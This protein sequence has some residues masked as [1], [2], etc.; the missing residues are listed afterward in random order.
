VKKKAKAAALDATA[1]KGNQ[2]GK[3]QRAARRRSYY[4][5]QFMR[6]S[7]NKRRRLR[8]HLRAHPKDQRAIK[9]YEEELCFGS[10]AALGLSG[11]GRKRLRE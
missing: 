10:V 9:A 11:R 4:Q 7:A 5:A 6:T 3:A 2:K 8:R 1:P